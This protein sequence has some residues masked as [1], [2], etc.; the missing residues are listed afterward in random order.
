MTTATLTAERGALARAA[1]FVARALSPRPPAAILSG[2]LIAP[3]DGGITLM[4]GD[5]D[6]TA[7]A[8]VPTDGE[9][10][11]PV[12]APGY[13]L[14]EWLASARGPRVTLSVTDTLMVATSG[15][16]RASMSLMPA[17]D[18]PAALAM[19]ASTLT[20]GREALTDALGRVGGSVGRDRLLPENMAVY[21]VA[22]AGRV[23][24]SGTNRYAMAHVSVS[25]EG[26]LP[27]VSP[28]F[29]QLAALATKMDGA[30]LGLATNRGRL[31]LI[32]ATTRAA[33]RTL[34]DQKN[35]AGS[36]IRMLTA[37]DSTPRIAE[38]DADGLRR[39]VALVAKLAAAS[40][41]DAERVRITAADGLAVITSIGERATAEIASEPIE[42]DGDP[43]T[44]ALNAS[45]LAAAL[46][47]VA[48][49]RVVISRAD[50]KPLLLHAPGSPGRAALMPLRS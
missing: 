14:T 5:Y 31:C 33:V 44:I 20:I 28:E 21:L 7:E 18:Y 13:L 46:D 29:R 17:G 6:T 10:S 2:I 1:A 26:E 3:A 50:R 27:R 47:C 4:A 35:L 30:T 45:Y 39:E 15:A 38:V 19:P 40:G 43:L 16:T 41:G 49:G 34:D 22:Q 24:L 9:L 12:V 37:L 36:I 25:G 11:R 8:Y 23:E 48:A 42:W 32:G